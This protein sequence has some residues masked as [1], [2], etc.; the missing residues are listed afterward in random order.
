MSAEENLGLRDVFCHVAVLNTDS[1]ALLI[2]ALLFNM[3]FHQPLGLGTIGN[4]IYM[5]KSVARWTV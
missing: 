1:P 4:G 2:A 3:M 5:F